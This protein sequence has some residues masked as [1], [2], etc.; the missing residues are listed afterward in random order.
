MSDSVGGVVTMGWILIF[1]AVVAGYMAFNV[2]YTKAFRMKNKI[3]DCYNKYGDDCVRVSEYRTELVDYAKSIGYHPRDNFIC[4]SSYESGSISNGKI[5]NYFCYYE[6]E[7]I[8]NSSDPDIVEEEEYHYY[9]IV[10]K[11]DI[12][13]PIV[14]NMFELRFLTVYGDTKTFKKG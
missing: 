14:Q 6:Y 1:I 11:V 13:I 3:I 2:N 10:T 8:R 7:K 4:P 9:K 5:D 12:D